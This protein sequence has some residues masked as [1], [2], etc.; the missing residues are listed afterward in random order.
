LSA[1]IREIE[2]YLDDGF[3]IIGL[4]RGQGDEGREAFVTLGDVMG[5]VERVTIR[6]EDEED[7]RYVQERFGRTG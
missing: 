4:Q 1:A 3:E 7:E 5:K 2:Q 6:L